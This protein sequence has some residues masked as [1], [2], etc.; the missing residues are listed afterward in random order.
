M[1][2]CDAVLMEKIAVGALAMMSASCIASADWQ[3]HRQCLNGIPAFVSHGRSD[4]DLS[5]DAG[6]R[7]AAFLVCAG[8]QVTWRPFEGGHEI[9][10]PVWRGFKRFV[11]ATMRE[12]LCSRFGYHARGPR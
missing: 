12:P 10:F 1:L 7:L 3:D 5:F 8:A 6:Q 4:P 11:Q 2:A 9:P